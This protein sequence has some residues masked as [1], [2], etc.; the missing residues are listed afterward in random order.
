MKHSRSHCGS[1][2]IWYHAPPG[3]GL[4]ST[5]GGTGNDEEAEA[6]QRRVAPLCDEG[7]V[8]PLRRLLAEAAEAG[9]E[10]A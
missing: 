8:D 1:S 4:A 7:V 9:A 10:A 5:L 6:V 2:S 3:S